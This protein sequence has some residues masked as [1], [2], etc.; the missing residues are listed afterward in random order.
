[1]WNVRGCGRERFLSDW[2]NDFLRRFCLN[3]RGWCS[4][5]IIGVN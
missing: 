1:M 3:K 5:K 2:I 4:L